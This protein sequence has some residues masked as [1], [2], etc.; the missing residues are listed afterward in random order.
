MQGSSPPTTI[1]P[2][3]T[4]SIFRKL[5]P[6]PMNV[7]LTCALFTMLATRRG[8]PLLDESRRTQPDLKETQPILVD[9]ATPKVTVTPISR[10]AQQPSSV[11]PPHPLSS[12]TAISTERKY[13]TDVAA[14]ARRARPMPKCVS[15]GKRAKSFLMVFMGHSGSSAIL[16]EIREHPDV[17]MD[18]MELVD[19]Q[20]Q[21]NSTEAAMTTRKFFEEGFDMGKVPG[22]KIRPHHLLAAPKLFR[23]ILR[24]FDT[25]LIW[26]YRQ[27]LFKSSIGEY[28]VRY[29][30]DVRSIEGLRENLSES[31]RCAH[32]AGCSFPVK[33]VGFLHGLLQSKVNSHNLITASI[34]EVAGVSGCVREVPYEDYL[35]GRVDTMK[36]IF[37][38]LG[39]P[40]RK[41]SPKRFK[42]TG[43]NLCKVVENWQDICRQFYGCITWQHMLDDTRNGCFCDATSGPTR[44]CQVHVVR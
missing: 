30:R 31:A 40:L 22:F 19:H 17:H 18:V 34:H 16:S 36:D 42:A 28:A 9:A 23:A 4:T 44:Y 15:N 13:D 1:S 8:L 32:A 27:N 14:V 20:D 38:F 7:I 12:N 10:S 37:K 39:L 11:P 5:R 24:D 6:S 2:Q 35:Y 25:R 41:T 33:D 26:Q 29:L 21:F 43:D 3:T